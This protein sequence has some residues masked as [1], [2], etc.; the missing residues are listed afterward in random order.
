MPVGILLLT[1]VLGAVVPL[2][3]PLLLTQTYGETTT[4][5]VQTEQLVPNA[6]YEL[7]SHSLG[8]VPALFAVSVGTYVNASALV[9]TTTLMDDANVRIE[10]DANGCLRSPS[11]PLCGTVP[12]YVDVF[13]R[14]RTTRPSPPPVS[15]FLTLRKN[16]AG[17]P[18]NVPLVVTLAMCCVAAALAVTFSLDR[19][20]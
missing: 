12:V 20:M 17:L 2:D 5:E 14:G 13:Y 7:K 15:Y 19:W 16:I 9:D 3:T 8:S 4:V 18:G 1:A 6:A 11:G 10:T